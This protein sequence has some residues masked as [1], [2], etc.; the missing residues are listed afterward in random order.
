MIIGAD[1]SL[2]V[3]TD[4]ITTFD[5]KQEY[6]YLHDA[7]WR[8]HTFTFYCNTTL[9]D[10]IENALSYIQ[11]QPNWIYTIN[12][13]HMTIA[14]AYGDVKVKDYLCFSFQDSAGHIPVLFKEAKRKSVLSLEEIVWLQLFSDRVAAGENRIV[15]SI[16]NNRRIFNY[17]ALSCLLRQVQVPRHYIEQYLQFTRKHPELKLL[18]SVL[19]GALN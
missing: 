11:A 3:H 9:A 14:I 7:E 18:S 2:R 17:D 1:S 12:K 6:V 16:T 13:D 4:C 15:R 10:F 8:T 5:Q 19:E